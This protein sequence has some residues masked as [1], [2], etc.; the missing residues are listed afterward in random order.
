MKGIFFFSSHVPVDVVTALSSLSK[1][2][3]IFPTRHK[4]VLISPASCGE[5]CPR[6][7]ALRLNS[8]RKG[9]ALG[10]LPSE[11]QSAL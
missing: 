7:W 10:Q 11:A 8:R 5:G 1:S 6:A 4:A 9:R 2:N 3:F